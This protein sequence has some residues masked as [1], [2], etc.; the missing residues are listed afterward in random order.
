MIRES[1]DIVEQSVHTCTDVDGDGVTDILAMRA[2]FGGEEVTLYSGKSFSPIWSRQG[3][4][5]TG[6]PTA[7]VVHAGVG[8][9]KSSTYVA[10]GRVYF[11]NTDS[12]GENGE[13]VLMSAPNG[14]DVTRLREQDFANS[15]TSG[16]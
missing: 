3:V 8:T 9:P 4:I 13:V 15:L 6:N 1:D 16:R 14:E 5:A 11:V 10:V 7:T 12:Y 2:P